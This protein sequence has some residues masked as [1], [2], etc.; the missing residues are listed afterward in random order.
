MKPNT[1]T[2]AAT[3]DLIASSPGP[4]HRCHFPINIA[5]QRCTALLGFT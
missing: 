3:T 2:F 4:I 5:V 1:P